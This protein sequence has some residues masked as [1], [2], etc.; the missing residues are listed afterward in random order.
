MGRTQGFLKA[1][2]WTRPHTDSAS[3]DTEA[4]TQMAEA[5]EDSMQLSRAQTLI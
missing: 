5:G 2:T 3:E 1:E 4:L